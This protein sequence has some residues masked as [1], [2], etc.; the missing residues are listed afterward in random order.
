AEFRDTGVGVV[1]SKYFVANR[2]GQFQ[3][4]EAREIKGGTEDRNT[5]FRVK[6]PVFSTRIR[7]GGRRIAGHVGN[8]F[9][10]IYTLHQLPLPDRAAEG[11][12]D[13]AGW[14]LKQ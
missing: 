9:D 7:G 11:K 13:T 6:R 4:V 8:D 12:A 14:Q 5:R 3:G 10:L 2:C 1:I